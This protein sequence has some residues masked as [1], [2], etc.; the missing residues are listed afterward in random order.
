LLLIIDDVQWDDPESGEL[1]REIVRA[2]DAPAALFIYV[3]RSDQRGG[4]AMLRELAGAE[5][6]PCHVLEIAAPNLADGD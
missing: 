2:P 4:S 3:C 1:L 6:P 5:A